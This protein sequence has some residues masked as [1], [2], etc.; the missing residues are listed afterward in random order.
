[1]TL[2]RLQ[3]TMLD[4]LRTGDPTLAAALGGGPGPAVYLNNHRAAPCDGRSAS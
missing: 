4:W 3:H 2:A 1:M